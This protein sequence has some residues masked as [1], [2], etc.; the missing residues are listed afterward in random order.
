MVGSPP[1]F[2]WLYRNPEESLDRLR[3]LRKAAS[4]AEEIERKRIRRLK[5]R[6]IQALTKLAMA[7]QL[8][9]R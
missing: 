9:G 5:A 7:G 6:R 8:K 4:K 3:A 2:S 1:M